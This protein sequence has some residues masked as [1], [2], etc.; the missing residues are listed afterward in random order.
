MSYLIDFHFD[1]ETRSRLDLKQVGTVR[2][3]TDPST[4]AT[5]LTWCF[6]RTGSIKAWRYG[7][8]IP[9]EVLDVALNPQKYRFNAFN[10]GFDY[11]IWTQ[12]FAKLI[13]N[14][15][16]PPIENLED[17]M[18]LTCHA[19]LGA[20]LDAAAKMRDLPYSKDKDGRRIML[21]QC[22]P[23]AK[24]EF[25]TLTDDEWSKFEYY[26]IVD[27][28]I[29]RDVYYSLP[30]LPA[31]ERWAFEWTFKRNLRGIRIDVDLVNEMNSI[32]E[33]ITPKL[34]Q[35]FDVLVMGKVKINSTK[36]KDFFKEYYPWIE[37]MQADTVR[38]M[39]ASNIQVHPQ[40]RRALEI[41]DLAGSTSLAKVKCAVTQ[42]YGHR[43]YGV[44]SYHYAHTKRWAGRGIQIQNFPRVDDKKP[45]KLDF[46][47]NVEDLTSTVRSMRPN[48]KDPL[49]F[50]KNLLRRIWIPDDGQAFYCGDFSRVEP[51]V[52]YWLLDLGN[53]PPK[54]YEEMAAEIYSL[55][56]ESIGKDS[57]ER[58]V[59]KSANL[60]C[61]YGM[62]WVKFK[63][64]THKKT[65]ILL[66]DD[67]AKQVVSAY[68]RKNEKITKFWKETEWAFRKAVY[69][70]P[71]SL[72]NGKVHFMPMQAPFKGVQIRLPSGSYLY[73]HHARV[74][75][76]EY[77]DQVVTMEHGT[78]VVISNKKTREILTYVTD[79]GG[80]L[81]RSKLYGGLL[82]EHITSAT[83]RDILVPAMWRL[84]NAGFDV[85][86][87]VHDEIW[88][89]TGHGRDEEFKKLMCI[90]PSWCDMKIDADLK[91][92]VRY[93]K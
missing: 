74:E 92:G 27:T 33:E 30:S 72:C 43:I 60:G 83:A 11:L 38:D 53:I 52:L 10:M 17:T 34:I 29:L 75:V 63:A 19:R 66:S 31:P 23:N 46:D 37:N 28:K 45:D 48:L 90:N 84:E 12:V 86:N 73:Y 62:G 50:V 55:P 77:T 24:G 58:T 87:V 54:W 76:E 64:D 93:L 13:P 70:E 47:M 68:R 79:E 51:S 82:T 65:G 85:L 6:G 8:A 7:Q 91:C 42:S 25:P 80:F 9:Q 71:S 21:K 3:A 2:Y 4:E 40:V 88:A 81:G 89:Q 39:L 5:L 69:G 78:P 49:G 1:F 16:R 18:A 59:G 56:I 61:G 36:C 26:G 44:L 67:M 32:I 20:S 41:K 35:E 14:L 57:E 22:K 15:V